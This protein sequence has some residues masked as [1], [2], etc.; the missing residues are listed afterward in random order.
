MFRNKV[1]CG[2]I[3]KFVAKL[4]KRIRRNMLFEFRVIDDELI[5]REFFDYYVIRYEWHYLFKRERYV[6]EIVVDSF[7]ICRISHEYE[8]K[9]HVKL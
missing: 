2:N 7:G 3:E 8:G 1:P 6:T 4:F 9:R 5:K